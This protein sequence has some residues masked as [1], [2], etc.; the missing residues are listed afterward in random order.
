ML[1][2]RFV[3]SDRVERPASVIF[4]LP[5]KATQSCPHVLFQIDLRISEEH[6]NEKNGFSH[7]RLVGQ[8]FNK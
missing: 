4:L 6:K 7:G 2:A 8:W 3:I 1:L 5:N